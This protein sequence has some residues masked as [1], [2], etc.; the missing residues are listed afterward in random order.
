MNVNNPTRRP[1]GSDK[2]GGFLPNTGQV[3]IEGQ[4]GDWT[5]VS[6]DGTRGPA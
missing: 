4:P 1:A 2:T 5:L 6:Y 3:V